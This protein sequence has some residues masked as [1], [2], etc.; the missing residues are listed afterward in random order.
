MERMTLNILIFL[1]LTIGLLD[2][3]YS[4]PK[5]ND[6][7]D[8]KLVEYEKEQRSRRLDPIELRIKVEEK[9]LGG[10]LGLRE[11]LIIYREASRLLYNPTTSGFQKTLVRSSNEGAFIGLSKQGS[12]VGEHKIEVL[13]LAKKEKLSSRFFE[14]EERIRGGQ[15][16]IGVGGEW[17]DINFGG[18]VLKDLYELLDKIREK[19][20]SVSLSKLRAGVEVLMIEGKRTGKANEIYVKGDRGYLKEL[21]FVVEE[22]GYL[23]E[24]VDSINFRRVKKQIF[25]GNY[26]TKGDKLWLMGGSEFLMELEEPVIVDKGVFLDMKVGYREKEVLEEGKEGMEEEGVEEDMESVEKLI[27]GDE[28]IEIEGVEVEESPLIGDFKE[29]E[30][31]E[32]KEEGKEEG[33]EEGK[34]EGEEEG[35]EEGKELKK[36]KIYIQFM[37]K[38]GKM[39]SEVGI[40][41]ISSDVISSEEGKDTKG[42]DTKGKDTKGKDTKGKDTNR[43]ESKKISLWE[44]FLKE[45]MDR[46]R[47]D[48]KDK[49]GGEKKGLKRIQIDKILIVNGFSDREYGIEGFNFYKE[50]EVLGKN[51]GGYSLNIIEEAKDAKILFNGILIERG[52]NE[53]EGV[54][55]GVTLSLKA[56]TE[57]EEAL[58]VK[59]NYIAM[60]DQVEDFIDE[61][62][63]VMLYIKNLMSRK[64]KSDRRG[65]LKGDFRTSRRDLKDIE[66]E[67][68]EYREKN[69]EDRKYAKLSGEIFQGYITEDLNLRILKEK[70]REKMVL[71]PYSEE[72]RKEKRIKFLKQLG[73]DSPRVNDGFLDRET[74]LG[75]YLTLDKEELMRELEKDFEGVKE[76]FSLMSFGIEEGDRGIAVGVVEFINNYVNRVV[77][78]RVGVSRLGIIEYKKQE[79]ENKIKRLSRDYE[80]EDEKVKLTVKKFKTDI[81]KIKRVRVRG[82]MERNRFENMFG[83]KK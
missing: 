25:K 28:K 67:E 82:E 45:A 17:K 27:W 49:N 41:V 55:R 31:G 24:E 32:G 14:E 26:E 43:S 2:L 11:R 68:K 58:E 78:D 60:I 46:E 70:L 63:N 61:Y 37:T 72:R 50:N 4:Y 6:E 66:E 81:E 35:K 22:S 29:E 80:E 20:F 8:K 59:N 5:D 79:I 3:G 48:R 57:K 42:K 69:D 71:S 19:P 54:M 16:K 62:N 52:V 34:E 1:T 53:I 40:D 9:K 64:W 44:V 7:L 33:E 65:F 51:R 39:S 21:G 47:D 83:L 13:Q 12:Q 56:R 76:I 15:F 30:V 18:G 23:R 75:G 77:R 74:L 38:E 10:W 36:E 73:I